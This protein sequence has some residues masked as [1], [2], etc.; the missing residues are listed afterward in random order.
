MKANVGLLVALVFS[1]VLAAESPYPNELPGFKFYDQAKWRKLQPLDST[2][3]EMFAALGTKSTPYYDAG[4]NWQFD[5]YFVG[6]GS[7]NGH[8]LPKSLI[9]KLRSIE[10]VPKGRVSLAGFQFPEVFSKTDEFGGHG[11]VH[12]WD[13]YEDSHGLRYQIYSA[14]SEDGTIQS[15]DLKAIVYGPPRQLFERLSGCG[16]NEAP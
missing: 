13:V 4:P 12:R 6:E 9:G 5:A 3:E 16:Q 7:C 1:G 15:G 14:A 11:L 10:L 8:P 2:T